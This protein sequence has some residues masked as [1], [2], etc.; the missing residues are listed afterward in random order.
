MTRWLDALTGRVTM[1]RLMVI[2]LAA[3]AAIA[4]VL[5]L[6]PRALPFALPA[7]LLP[8]FVFLVVGYASNR[9]FGL[10]FRVSPHTE[11][12]LIT[13]L[14][15]FFLFL[16]TTDARGLLV[17]ALVALIATASKYLLAVRGRHIFNPVAIAALIIAFT[18][19]SAAG[20]WVGTPFLL[21]PVAIGAFLVVWRT[22]RFALVGTFLGVAFVITMVRFLALNIGFGDALSFAVGS[23][24]LVFFAGFMVDEPLTLPPRRWQQL[25]F[26]AVVGVLYSVPFSFGPF[27]TTPE[28]ALVVGNILAFAFAF[29]QRRS[30]A[31]HYVGTRAL[32]PTTRELVFAPNRSVTFR[33]GQYMELAMPHT[34]ADAR[35]VRRV[36]SV[37]SAP[38]A[39]TVTFG[40]KVPEV[41]SSFKR[42]LG[43]LQPGTRLHGTAIGGDFVLPSDSTVPLLLVAGGIGITPF[44][45]QLRHMTQSGEHRDVVVVYAVRGEDEFAYAEELEAAGVPVL[46]VAPNPPERMPAGWQY[47]GP[48]RLD[49]S[50]LADR[51]PRLTSRTAYVSGPP[52]MVTSL[53]REL[54]ALGIRRIKTD[55]FSGY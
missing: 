27:N 35:G 21:A 46:V 31:L 14:L 55:Y 11:S 25:V 47:L 9:L 16:P 51:V 7:L 52:A 6:I 32:T 18:Q 34:R 28:L 8:L 22:R 13:A 19:L 17:Y 48:G 5:S 12:A 50:V 29:A 54:R 37:S 24:P 41:S 20:W 15:L 1:Y 10:I 53:R 36:F 43:A 38:A 45:S 40:V 4:L 33:P 2:V 3:I 30:I 42:E 39:D 23:A 49:G 26:A 44:I